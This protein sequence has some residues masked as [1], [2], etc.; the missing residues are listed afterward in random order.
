MTLNK[1]DKKIFHNMINYKFK[2]NDQIYE[3]IDYFNGIP[4][5]RILW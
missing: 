3:D 2:D 5:E 4:N 1:I